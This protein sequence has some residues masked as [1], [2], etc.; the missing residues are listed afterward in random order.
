[1]LYTL[2]YIERQRNSRTNDLYRD[3]VIE[4][5]TINVFFLSLLLLSFK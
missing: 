2:N 5:R 4:L 3:G 1:L